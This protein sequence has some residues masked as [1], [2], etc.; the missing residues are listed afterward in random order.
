M[1]VLVGLD[2]YEVLDAVETDNGELVVTVQVARSDAPCPS[3]RVQRAGEAASHPAGAAWLELRA[4]DD[5]VLVEAS[6]PVRHAG[7]RHLHR[8]DG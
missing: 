6:V 2:E 5:P 8:V 1:R 4:T 3:W 7:V